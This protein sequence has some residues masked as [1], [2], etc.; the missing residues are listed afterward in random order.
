ML[1]N[2]ITPFLT[3]LRPATLPHLIIPIENITLLRTIQAYNLSI[4]SR[5]LHRFSQNSNSDF[6]CI[7]ASIMQ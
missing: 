2:H 4:C 5:L 7:F 1:A 6:H 3:L